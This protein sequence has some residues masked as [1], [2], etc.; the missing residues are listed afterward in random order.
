MKETIPEWE[1]AYP[2]KQQDEHRVSRRQF[3]A[4]CGCSALALSAGIPLR[5]VLRAIPPATDPIAVAAVEEVPRGGYK[6]FEYPEPGYPCILVRSL[7]GEYA[8]Y[9]QSCTHLMC[10]VHFDA[11]AHQLVCPCHSGY[12]DAKDGRVLAGPPQRALPRYQVAIEE[13]QVRV[14]PAW[15][16]KPTESI[17]ESV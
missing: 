2:I 15:E 11:Q 13:G 8:A 12:F 5:Q 3:A 14:G 7:E 4:F 1:K 17:A 6:L 9:S 10:P 16:T